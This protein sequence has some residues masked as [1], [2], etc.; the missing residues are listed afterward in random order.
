MVLA[1]GGNGP[2]TGISV[3]GAGCGEGGGGAA[4]APGGNG[5]PMGI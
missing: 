2:P 5:P 3:G 1:P 4:L